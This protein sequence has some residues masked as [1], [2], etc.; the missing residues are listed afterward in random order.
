[1]K[2]KVYRQVQPRAT[3]LRDA[4]VQEEIKNFLQALDSYPAR[5]AKE[6]DVTFQQHLCSIFGGGDDRRRNRPGRH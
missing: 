2:P 4:K 5:A 3:V 6:P 1:M